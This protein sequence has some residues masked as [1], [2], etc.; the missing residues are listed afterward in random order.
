V[1]DVEEKLNINIADETTDYGN[2]ILSN[3][4]VDNTY[5][6]QYFKFEQ[7][8]LDSIDLKFATYARE[9]YSLVTFEL[10][11]DDKIIWNKTI[12]ADTLG[13]YSFYK[14][15]FNDLKVDTNK[16]YKLKITTSYTTNFDYVS[17]YFS[18]Y[19]TS[20]NDYLYIN[21]EK[22]NYNLDMNLYYE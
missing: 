12:S 5:M 11:E 8:N 22:T 20:L 21:G 16:T 14:L 17:I 18:D 15:E 7:S 9:N 6:E 4:L 13:D 3:P 2:L 10:Y 1:D 19:T